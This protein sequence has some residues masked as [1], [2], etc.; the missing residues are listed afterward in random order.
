MELV[1]LT[2]LKKEVRVKGYYVND[3]TIRDKII[4]GGLKVLHK[5]ELIE[6]V[7]YCFI[8]KNCNRRS[9]GMNA[10]FTKHLIE[11]KIGWMEWSVSQWSEKALRVVTL[12]LHLPATLHIIA[13]LY[14]SS[15]L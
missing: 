5:Y 12:L 9:K 3:N 6:E 10:S 15:S 4:N 8:R 11:S 2:R 7:M 14:P 13:F 1:V